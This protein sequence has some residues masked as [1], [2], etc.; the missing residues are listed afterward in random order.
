[1]T[2]SILSANQRAIKCHDPIGDDNNPDKTNK[3]GEMR[4]T[5]QLNNEKYR[6]YRQESRVGEVP[7]RNIFLL[8]SALG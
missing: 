8:M 3:G 1:M 2:S 6:K 5:M 7:H 4:E